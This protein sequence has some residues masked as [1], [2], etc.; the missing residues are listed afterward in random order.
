MSNFEYPPIDPP[1]EYQGPNYPILV[2]TKWPSMLMNYDRA[3]IWC[4]LDEDFNVEILSEDVEPGA[5]SAVFS[6][7]SE[8]GAMD[9]LQWEHDGH[10]LALEFGI[11]YRQPFLLDVTVTW[12]RSGGYFEP[13]EWDMDVETKIAHVTKLSTEETIKRWQEWI[14]RPSAQP[15]SP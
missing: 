14:D 6:A 3:L 9:V 12:K 1:E 10:E 11:T 5:P 15:N 4:E 2:M 7:I 13:E 8:M